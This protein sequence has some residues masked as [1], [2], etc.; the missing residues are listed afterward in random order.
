MNKELCTFLCALVFAVEAK[1]GRTNHRRAAQIA[2]IDSGRVGTLTD[3]LARMGYI[4]Q[5]ATGLVDVLPAGIQASEECLSREIV[6]HEELG[7]ARRSDSPTN[8]KTVLVL[9]HNYEVGPIPEGSDRTLPPPE[10]AKEAFEPVRSAVAGFVGSA[11]TVKDGPELWRGSLQNVS[12]G[13][14]VTVFARVD[15]AFDV[16]DLRRHLSE[17]FP[18]EDLS[19]RSS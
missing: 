17:Q 1:P 5:V 16:D 13:G 2:G 12:E 3:Q 15:Q 19:V 9:L 8:Q 11:G 4:S 7:V 14:Y 10:G 6:T 18:E